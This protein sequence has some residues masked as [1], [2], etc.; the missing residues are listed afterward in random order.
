MMRLQPAWQ[1]TF[2]LRLL[3]R[4]GHVDPSGFRGS[5]ASEHFELRADV[6]LES[7]TVATLAVTSMQPYRR[8]ALAECERGARDLCSLLSLRLGDGRILEPFGE[9]E[10][11]RLQGAK[12]APDSDGLRFS[13]SVS[14]T[15]SW[16]LDVHGDAL[17]Q[18]EHMG[19]DPALRADLDAYRLVTLEEDQPTRLIH[20]SRIIDRHAGELLSD[21][22][23][24]LDQTQQKHCVSALAEALPQSLS[25]PERERLLSAVNGAVSR[26]RVRPRADVLAE[27]F[28]RLTENDITADQIRQITQA[29]GRYAHRTTALRSLG[30]Y[31]TEDLLRMLARATLSDGAQRLQGDA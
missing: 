13:E 3:G 14:V 15:A 11:E 2:R 8:D 5:V 29:R 16:G 30:D 12:D 9:A 31:E 20:L 21:E 28:S 27:T 19:E 17:E 25:A 18:A 24:L 4:G 23:P 6:D 22:P 1:I 10:I 26:V 7:G